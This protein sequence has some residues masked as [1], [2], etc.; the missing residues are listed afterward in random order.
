MMDS[1]AYKYGNAIKTYFC[2]LVRGGTEEHT[3]SQIIIAGK[4][5]GRS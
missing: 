1:V 4:I 2:D 5:I 3:E